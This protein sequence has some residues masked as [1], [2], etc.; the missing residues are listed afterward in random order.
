MQSQSLVPVPAY[1]HGV[2]AGRR[3]DTLSAVK[4]GD[5]RLKSCGYQA[6]EI[7]RFVAATNAY[8]QLMAV[9]NVRGGAEG[10]RNS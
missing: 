6:V 1:G 3:G 8:A 9:E 4:L 5:R 2:A 7:S 10:R